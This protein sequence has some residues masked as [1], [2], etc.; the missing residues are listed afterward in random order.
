[1]PDLGGFQDLAGQ[2]IHRVPGDIN[3]SDN[4]LDIIDTLCQHILVLSSIHLI[5]EQ[6][7]PF[8]VSMDHFE[9]AV[10]FGIDPGPAFEHVEIVKKNMGKQTLVVKEM[11]LDLSRS[12]S[13]DFP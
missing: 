5:F 8:E 6:G 4:I 10:E 11:A 9:L 2:V 12:N 3:W 7:E 13:E 1:M